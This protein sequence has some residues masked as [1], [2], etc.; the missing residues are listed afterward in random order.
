MPLLFLS[1]GSEGKLAS[2]RIVVRI[3]AQRVRGGLAT[4][5]SG[6]AQ[7]AEG[8]AVSQ[9]HTSHGPGRP[10]PQRVETGRGQD[11]EHSLAFRKRDWRRRD[12]IGRKSDNCQTHNAHGRSCSV[13]QQ[14]P[15]NSAQSIGAIPDGHDEGMWRAL[16][17]VMDRLPGDDKQKEVA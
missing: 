6:A 7:F 10:G 5:G 1:L 14:P 12:D 16:E 9:K 17:A 8:E 2:R 11:L 13:E 15:D 3:S 4:K